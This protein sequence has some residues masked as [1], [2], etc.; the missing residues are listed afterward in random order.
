[1]PMHGCEAARDAGLPRQTWQ[2]LLGW[3]ARR[4]KDH[5]Q[6]LPVSKALGGCDD[7]AC[8]GAWL[9]SAGHS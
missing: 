3:R 1:M 9:K 5:A 2:R 8:A 6:R 7:C 4:R